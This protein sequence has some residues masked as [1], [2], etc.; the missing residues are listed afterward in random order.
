MKFTIWERD[1]SISI[2]GS[3]VVTDKIAWY[4]VYY[5]CKCMNPVQDKVLD[6]INKAAEN[7]SL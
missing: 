4:L 7:V 1:D 6:L 3:C 2:I 5:E